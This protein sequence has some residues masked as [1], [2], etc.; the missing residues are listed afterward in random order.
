M[1]RFFSWFRNSSSRRRLSKDNSSEELGLNSEKLKE[2]EKLLGVFL[3]NKSRYIQAL[4]HRSF[5]ESNNHKRISNERLEFLG[6]SVLSLIV[7]Q[8]LFENFPD[9][10]EGF[11][12]KIRA[13]FVNRNSL[14]DTA[15]K[16]GISDF[17]FIG[18]NLSRT[19][20]NN[21]K[22]VLA[23]TLEALIGAI[24]LDRGIKECRKFIF[25]ILIKPNIKDDDYLIDE[26][27][28]S[29]LLEYTQANKMAPPL[30]EVIK[31][32][33]LQHER[34]F[35]VRVSVGKNEI[36]MGKAMSKKTAEQSAAR[37]ALTKIL[38]SD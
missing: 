14:G 34:V 1:S 23:D 26:N 29:Q 13:K 31:E 36:G 2:L 32:E 33:G 10:D 20:V 24:F 12:T 9:E 3:D 17:I 16:L 27:Y 4:T 37:I 11:L 15:E 28:K 25:K 18:D 35:T 19:F 22:T 30:Y 38:T 5:L 8:F 6:D 7:A 21:S